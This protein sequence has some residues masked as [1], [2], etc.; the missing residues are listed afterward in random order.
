[1]PFPTGRYELRGDGVTEPYRWVWIPNPPTEPPS[2]VPPTSPPP[3]SKDSGPARPA[4]LYRWTDEQG[5]VHYTDRSTAVP[6]RYR[7]RT[8][9]AEPS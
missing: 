2:P 6:D 8:R 7:A 9:Q 3:S 1:V 4:R 5:T